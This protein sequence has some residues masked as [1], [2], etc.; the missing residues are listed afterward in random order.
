M[1]NAQISYVF[2]LPIL[3]LGLAFTCILLQAIQKLNYQV[4]VCL[5]T[6]SPCSRIP[7]LRNSKF[8]YKL[9]KLTIL[10]KKTQNPYLHIMKELPFQLYNKLKLNVSS[11][12]VPVRGPSLHFYYNNENTPFHIIKELAFQLLQQTETKCLIWSCSRYISLPFYYNNENPPF[13]TL[14]RLE[15]GTS[16]G[17]GERLSQL[18]Y[19]LARVKGQVNPHLKRLINL[20]SFQFN[21]FIIIY[22]FKHRKQ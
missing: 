7:I 15:P 18:G 19:P 8:A 1:K 22:I 12:P 9:I 17:S 20:Y 3:Q 6:F 11:V 21:N 14:V 13:P 16:P 10:N 5:E 2:W 4:V